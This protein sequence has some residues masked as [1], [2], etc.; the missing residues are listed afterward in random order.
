MLIYLAIILFALFLFILIIYNS[1]IF[2]RNNANKAFATID[3]MLKKRFDL[4]PN[5]VETV[6]AYASHERNTLEQ[7]VKLRAEAMKNDISDNEKIR[8]GSQCSP[9]LSRII[10]ISENYPELKANENF[11]NL[12]RNLTEIEEQISAARRAYNAAVTDFN[13][14]CEMFPGNIFAS[15]FGFS[16]K[17]LFTASDDEKKNQELKF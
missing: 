14:A 7:I 6:K 16:Q 9:L 4:I 10:A 13:N 8:L 17:A 2:K 5:L 11:L 3:V 1:F 12:Q 15:I